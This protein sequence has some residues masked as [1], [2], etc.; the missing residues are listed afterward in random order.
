MFKFLMFFVFVFLIGC[1]TYTRF[2]TLGEEFEE[3]VC[4][5]GESVTFESYLNVFSDSKLLFNEKIKQFSINIPIV[6]NQKEVVFNNNNEIVDGLTAP[7]YGGISIEFT[8]KE[9]VQNTSLY[10]ELI[11]AFAM[12]INE[13]YNHDNDKLF[14]NFNN[15]FNSIDSL[16]N[17]LYYR[18]SQK[19]NDFQWMF[20]VKCIS[21]NCII[22]NFGSYCFNTW[23]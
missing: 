18:L 15:C 3:N 4:F 16:E 22:S 23:E 21:N 11:H 7:K 12:E 19:Y 10:H 2:C 8:H 20:I 14:I 13:N 1:G 9:K 5:V 17:Q 6:I